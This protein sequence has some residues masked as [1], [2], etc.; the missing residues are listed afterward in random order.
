M[1]AQLPPRT[2]LALL[3]TP[4]EAAE[5]LSA[6]WG[7]PRIWVKRDDLTGFGLSGNKVRKLEF[8]FAAAAAAGADTV[9]TC[10]A[11]QSNHSRATALAAARLGFRV[12]LL[13]RRPESGTTRP[14]VGNLLL[15]ALAGA[16]I[17][18][19]APAEW[20]RRNE[21][22]AEVAAAER[23]TGHTAWVIPEGASDALGMWGFVL[24]MQELADQLAAVPGNQATVWHAASSGG[25]TAGIGWAADRLG[26]DTPV[27]ACSIGDPVASLRDKV[28]EIWAEAAAQT[29]ARKPTA[30]IDY[31]DRHIGAGYGMVTTEDLAVQ[32]EATSLTG[33]IFDP[34]YTGKA[35]VGLR[36]EIEAGTFGKGDNVVF[37]HTGGGFA[38]FAHDFSRIDVAAAQDADT[39]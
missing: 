11:L 1:T 9:V 14:L 28:E 10:G 21:L 4:L 31:I 19:M 35:L 27:A 13:L 3:P 38:V 24:A 2:P 33:L 7:G 5:R 15:D 39:D 37:W 22:M 17:R 6:A 32:A 12:I 25:T 8:H 26:L 29:G 18:Y 20:P 36:R 30:L 16:Q 23:T 34:T